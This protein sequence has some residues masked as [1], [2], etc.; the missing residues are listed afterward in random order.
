M[1][2]RTL[3]KNRNAIKKADLYELLLTAE[4]ENIEK[5]IVKTWVD[6]LDHGEN[7]EK[8]GAISQFM[9][10]KYGRPPQAV[11]LNHDVGD[12]IDKITIEVVNKHEDKGD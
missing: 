11:D 1:N 7:N 4:K 8:L 2:R 10:Y 5:K 6:I 9:N 12:N 3:S